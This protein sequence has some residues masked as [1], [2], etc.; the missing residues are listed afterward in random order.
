M[1]ASPVQA[2]GTGTAPPSLN[3]GKRIRQL[4]GMV[5][6]MEAVVLLLAIVPAKVL[7]HISGGVAASVGLGLAALAIVLGGIVG[8]PHMGWVLVAG[9]VFQALVIASGVKIPAMYV[10]GAVFAALWITGIWLARRI[11]REVFERQQA[12]T[13]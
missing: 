2:A 7:E 4:C 6:I 3:T 8:R 9:T 13:R 5:L 10:L 11:Q 1:T 12:A